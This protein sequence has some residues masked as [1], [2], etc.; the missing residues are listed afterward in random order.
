M[1]AKIILSVLMTAI[2]MSMPS[3]GENKSDKDNV[4]RYE[5]KNK[6]DISGAADNTA[7]TE[8]N[9]NTDVPDVPQGVFEDNIWAAFLVSPSNPAYKDQEQGY[10]ILDVLCEDSVIGDV[11]SLS[12]SA[13]APEDTYA[14]G[15]EVITAGGPVGYD[16][17]AYGRLSEIP[18]SFLN[19]MVKDMKA[20]IGDYYGDHDGGSGMGY[21]TFY[22]ASY[23]ADTGALQANQSNGYWARTLGAFSEHCGGVAVDF[24]ISYDNSEYLEY[25]GADNKDGDTAANKEFSWLADNAHK[26]GFIWR[27]KIDGSDESAYGFETGTIR[28]GWHWRFVGVYN[29]TKFWEKCAADTDGD[30]TPDS[31][32]MTNDEYIWEDYYY[33][34]INGNTKYPQTEYEAFCSFYNSEKGNRCSYD[35]YK[36]MN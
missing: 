22:Q 24:N 27:Y 31:G 35:E 7:G 16:S 3:C 23:D 8:N 33:E 30:G 26:Y 4:M 5:E 20:E 28:E 12:R 6:T 19:A 9:I 21:R 10:E 1:K 13:R 2:V 11:A 29:A 25:S 34:N 36:R 18:D 17:L 14:Y 15:T 32:Y